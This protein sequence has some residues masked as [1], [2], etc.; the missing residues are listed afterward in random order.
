[1]RTA[2][3][4]DERYFGVDIAPGGELVVA[5]R[6]A[7]RRLPPSHFPAGTPGVAA[8]RRHIERETAHAHVCIP[9]SRSGALGLATALVPVRGIEVTLVARHALREEGASTPEARAEG[10]ARLAERLF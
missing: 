4:S 3:P 6:A 2:L 5:E 9:A 8:L 7:G 10:L 1:V